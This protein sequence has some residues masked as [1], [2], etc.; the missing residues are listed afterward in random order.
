[1][2]TT[3]FL[4]AM[5][6]GC[7]SGKST[8]DSGLGTDSGEPAGSAG[9]GVSPEPVVPECSWFS[10]DNCWKQTVRTVDACLTEAR[11]AGVFS[12]NFQ[13]CD[14]E[15]GSALTL[16]GGSDFATPFEWSSLDLR[17]FSMTG[18]DGQTCVTYLAEESG[19]SSKWTLNTTDGETRY[20]VSDLQS[21]GG[22]LTCPDGTAYNLGTDVVSCPDANTYWPFIAHSATGSFLTY[23][24]QGGDQATSVFTCSSQ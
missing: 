9:S 5:L 24:L 22:I 6:I 11:S 18:A 21:L 13:T 1:M 14:F 17:G 10:E 23:S 8:P 15:D 12:S 3:S 20:E 7:S 19:N 16:S 4:L 2:R